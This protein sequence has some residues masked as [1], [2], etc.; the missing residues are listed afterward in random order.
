MSFRRYRHV[1][2]RVALYTV[3][4]VLY[5]RDQHVMEVGYIYSVSFNG[6]RRCK[7]TYLM[8]HTIGNALSI[9]NYCIYPW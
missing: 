7:L 8:L 5:Q 1:T 2:S 6:V 3:T 9:L 4:I